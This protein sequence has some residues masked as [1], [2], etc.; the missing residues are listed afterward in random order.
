MAKLFSNNYSTTSTAGIS[1]TDTTITVTTTTGLPLIGSGNYCHLT[2]TDSLT[3]PTVTEIVKAT[4]VGGSTLTIVRAQ[5][6]TA[7]GTWASGT[8]VELRATADAFERL[9]GT[10]ITLYEEAVNLSAAPAIDRNNGG[11]Q[12]LTLTQAETI[13]LSN[14]TSGRS[15]VLHL[16]NGLTYTP[17]WPTIS[18]VGGSAP[19]L[20]DDCAISLWTVNTTTYGSLIGTF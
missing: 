9:D 6:N 7:A 10:E 15:M 5:E 17:T 1:D 20:T 16:I 2:L 4:S 13:T 8:F 19:T 3:A 12:V 11:I 18:W 14:L